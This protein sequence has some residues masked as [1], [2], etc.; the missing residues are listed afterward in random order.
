MGDSKGREQ[1]GLPKRP[2]TGRTWMPPIATARLAPA[3][4]PQPVP[5]RADAGLA[6]TDQTSVDASCVPLEQAAGAAPLSPGTA[7]L[8]AGTAA[9]VVNTDNLGVVLRAAPRADARLPR[10]LLEGARVTVLGAQMVSPLASCRAP[11]VLVDEATE[12]IA[13][14]DLHGRLGRLP[15]AGHLARTRRFAGAPL[16]GRR[17]AGRGRAK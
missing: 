1:V 13:P 4:P 12:P 2:I 9:R 14:D 10:G 17:G 11:H 8:H 6:S 15:C 16:A 5:D 3:A 7:E